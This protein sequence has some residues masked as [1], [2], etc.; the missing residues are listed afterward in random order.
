LIRTP[1]PFALERILHEA[2]KS[3]RIGERRDYFTLQFEDLNDI[4]KIAENVIVTKDDREFKF[5]R[6]DRTLLVATLPSDLVE[7]AKTYLSCHTKY[8][9]MSHFV[10]EA[11]RDKL[12]REGFDL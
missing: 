6:Q 3:Q 9:N 11:L 12:I 10:E 1:F 8:R 4:I 5:T 7:H 2:F